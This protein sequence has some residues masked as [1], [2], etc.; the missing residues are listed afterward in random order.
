M[1]GHDTRS[2]NIP[3]KKFAKIIIRKH[4]HNCDM[5]SEQLFKQLNIL[6][7]ADLFYLNALKFYYKYLRDELPVYFIDMFNPLTV[8]HDYYTRHRDVPQYDQSNKMSASK[9]IRY[10]IPSILKD[11][12]FLHIVVV[13]VTFTIDM[14]L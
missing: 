1:E 8:T 11:L 6:K 2:N 9:C 13:I 10:H 7:V 14:S 5:H 4:C 12:D 3:L